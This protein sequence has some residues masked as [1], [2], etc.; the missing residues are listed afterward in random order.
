MSET[1][2]NAG[3]ESDGNFIELVGG[4]MDGDQIE[5]DPGDPVVLPLGEAG[6]KHRHMYRV[7]I[8]NGETIARYLGQMK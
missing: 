2:W 5:Y 1:Y 3:K 8:A 6:S 4:P 7:E